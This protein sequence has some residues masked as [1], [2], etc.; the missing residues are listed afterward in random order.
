MNP[1][2]CDSSHSSNDSLNGKKKKQRDAEQKIRDEI[3]AALA[4]LE[5]DR[6]RQAAFQ[7]LLACVQARTELLKPTHGE[8]SVGW[9]A[10]A[11]LINRL[12]NLAARQAHWLRSC[13]T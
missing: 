12:K 5:S 2:T 7:R 3:K 4:Q 1:Y 6:A 9:V 8:G 13:E 11:F 10:P